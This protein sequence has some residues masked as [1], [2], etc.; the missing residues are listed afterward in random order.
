MKTDNQ[1]WLAPPK[2]A[3]LADDEVH[4]W[5]TILDLP[6]AQVQHL[7]SL[8]T[9]DERSRADNF[10]FARDRRHFIAARGVLRTI[11]GRY[12]GVAPNDLRFCYNRHGKPFLTSEFS[13]QALSFNL[14][15]ASGLALYAVVR[16]REIGIDVERIHTNFDYEDIA[17]R[18]FSPSEIAVLRTIS[19]DSKPKAFFDCWTRKEAY[20]KAQGDGLSLPLHSFDVSF[21]PDGPARFLAIRNNKQKASNWTLH[22]LTPGNGYVGALAV[23]GCDW[24][25]KYWQWAEK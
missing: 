19:A 4:V 18:F 17:E 16:G 6:S 12:L 5:R 24:K 22:E 8:L 3:S 20:I 10:H 13:N 1:L 23:E 14:S 25:Y 21:A 7:W 11:L 15:H 9:A 2:K